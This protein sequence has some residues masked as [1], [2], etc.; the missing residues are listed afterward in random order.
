M[1]LFETIAD[2]EEGAGRLRCRP[3]GVIEMVDG[4]FRRVL[5]RPFPK[6]VTAPGAVLIGRWRH[7]NSRGDRLRLYYNQPRRFRNFLVLKYVESTRNTSMAS[8]TRALGILDEIARL[9]ASD[10]LLCDVSNWRVTDK[11]I[12]RWGWAPHCPSRFHRHYIKRFYGSYPTAA[13][14]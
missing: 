3:Y 13:T 14:C 7:D 2:L 6:I 10:A 4:Q 12:G 11:L 9:K 8:L 5:F 1:P